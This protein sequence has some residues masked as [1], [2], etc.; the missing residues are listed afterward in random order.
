V[1]VR[2]V[3]NLRLLG[4]FGRSG[5]T[6][7]YRRGTNPSLFAWV[8]PAHVG[9]RIV[10]QLQARRPGGPWSSPAT[11]SFRIGPTGRVRVVITGLPSNLTYRVRSQFR[12]DADHLGSFSPWNAFRFA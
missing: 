10:L 9:R 1:G 8:N 3:A 2:A 12:A 11:A 4:W 7:L 6:K 5:A